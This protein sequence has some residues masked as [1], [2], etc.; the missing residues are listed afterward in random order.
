[1]KNLFVFY[2]SL[3]AL[4]ASAQKQSKLKVFLLPTSHSW[5]SL[6]LNYDFD[7]V[8]KQV[9]D[10]KPELIFTEY[11]NP[12]FEKQVT[13]YWNK[14][15]MIQTQASIAKTKRYVNVEADIKSLEQKVKL[16]PNDIQLRAN[17]MHAYWY[18]WD[19]G[20][21]NYQGYYLLKLLAVKKATKSDTVL[22]N[23]LFGNIDSLVT[24]GIVRRPLNE[25]TRICF[26]LAE[27]LGINYLDGMDSQLHDSLWS[28]YWEE[29]DKAF[30]E[31]KANVCKDSTDSNCKKYMAVRSEYLKRKAYNDKE[32]D[33][34]DYTTIHQLFASV[35]YDSTCYWGDFKTKLYYNLEGYPKQL[36][37]K[38]YG[39]WYL[40]NLDMCTNIVEGMKKQNK[41]RS[42]VIVGA[43]HGYLMKDL[44]ANK[45]NVEVVLIK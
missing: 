38:K 29:S 33:K 40:R 34:Y 6:D 26:P 32:K 11:A 43:S 8:F 12:Q 20:N 21:G 36:F 10:F 24:W 28:V 19:R 31:W 35:A 15:F 39:Q 4:T 2:I 18:N 25:Y 17:L 22:I 14:E 27:K 45:F 16:K 5:D 44:L 9:L 7:K 41:S 30:D 42:F 23:Q 37:E 1:M 3:L 13:T